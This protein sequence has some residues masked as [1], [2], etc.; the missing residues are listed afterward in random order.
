MAVG[1]VAIPL[2]IRGMGVASLGILSLAWIA[3]GYFSLFDLGIGQAL[4]KLVADKLAANEEHSIPP[5]AWMALLLMLLLGVMGGLVTLAISP[6]LV[7]SA[8]K[9]PAA[10]QPETLRSFFLLAL[11]IPLVT[12]TSRLRGILETQQPPERL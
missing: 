11:S 5:L 6:W 9:V 7:H 8:V 2:L 10:L 4:T 3:V 12:V 1:V